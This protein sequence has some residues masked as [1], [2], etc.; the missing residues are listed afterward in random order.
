MIKKFIKAVTQGES[1]SIEDSAR[2]FQIVMS[3][4]A[5]PAQIAALVVALKMKG[6]SVGEI[7]G[8]ATAMR[9]KMTTIKSP[10]IAIDVCGTGG[11][12]ASD[13]GSTLNVS[14]AVAIVT[15]ACGLPVAK[16]GNKS[17]SSSSGS[18]DVLAALGVNI[19]AEPQI[20]E[21][22]LQEIGLCFMFAPLYHKAMRHVAPIRQ[23]LAIR[24]IFNLLG[25]LANPANPPFQ[26][27]G[28]YSRDLLVPMAEVL[29]LL[30][31]KRAWVVHGSDG[32]DELTI[33]GESYVA[34]LKDA[35]INLF[36]LSPQDA[37]LEIS[38]F[39]S[40]KG[41]NPQSNAA[42]LRALLGGKLSPYRDVVLL[43][44]SASLLI[45]GLVDN[46][47]DGVA[48][49]ADAID[50]SKALKILHDLAEISSR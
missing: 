44:V 29:R 21:Q 1:L 18:A 47:K 49:G 37:D 26:L 35:E 8:A 41:K 4:G 10:E 17:V 5:T 36:T 28:V 13:K 30:G 14:T 20:S 16:H 25:P 23:E 38:E 42:E 46:L 11:D 31:S 27:M 33:T 39:D 43:N 24:T 3:G 22:S 15:A 40:I 50:S 2:A 12:A 45:G 32:M 48:M 7:A 19:Q 9:T 6:E 34:E